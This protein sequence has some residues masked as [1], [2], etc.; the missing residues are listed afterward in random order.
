M[1]E[2]CC[3][4]S[5]Q[6]LAWQKE[7]TESPYADNLCGGHASLYGMQAQLCEGACGVVPVHGLDLAPLGAPLL[8]P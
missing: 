1:V 6:C 4:S 5:I 3:F 7:Q 2:L 8:I